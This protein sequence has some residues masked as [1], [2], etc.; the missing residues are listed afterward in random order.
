MV[1]KV[2]EW[3]DSYLYDHEDDRDI[4]AGLCVVEETL[5]GGEQE[6]DEDAQDEEILDAEEALI[7]AEGNTGSEEH[8]YEHESEKAEETDADAE[9]C[10]GP[11]AFELTLLTILYPPPVLLGH[12]IQSK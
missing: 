8:E 4:L 10:G 1:L 6:G 2:P 11:D 5:V 12:D 9:D 7:D 3:H